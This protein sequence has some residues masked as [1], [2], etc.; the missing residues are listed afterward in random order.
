MI[1]SFLKTTLV[2][3]RSQAKAPSFILVYML[4]A[5]VWHNQFFITLAVYNG[6]LSEKL[7]EALTE[8]SFQYGVVLCLTALFFILRLTFLYLVNK[9]DNFIDNEEPIEAKIAS[10]QVFTE[11][12]DV[13]RLL[14]LLEDTKA[15][16]AKVKS[17]EALAQ[18]DKTTTISKILAMQAELDL[19]QADIAILSQSNE[20]LRAKLLECA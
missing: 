18:T 14:A 9:T 6:N 2:F 11:N 8:S 16:L 3:N 10:D 17:R 1:S 15:E 12:K 7:A 4:I 5:L 20:D 19:A 13:V